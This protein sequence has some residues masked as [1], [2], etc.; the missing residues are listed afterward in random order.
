MAIKSGQKKD[1]EKPLSFGNKVVMLSGG[2]IYIEVHS[3]SVIEALFGIYT[4]DVTYWHT[5]S[6]NGTLG[7]DRFSAIKEKST[8]NYWQRTLK[9]K[10]TTIM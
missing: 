4:A 7:L 8:S 6:E 2:F 9:N 10:M 3:I 5:S 1:L